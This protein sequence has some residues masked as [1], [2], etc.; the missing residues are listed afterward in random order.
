[1]YGAAVQIK[2]VEVAV[3]IRAVEHGP[4]VVTIVVVVQPKRFLQVAPLPLEPLLRVQLP[5]L[6]RELVLEPLRP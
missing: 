4:D 1:M 2:S 3:Q 6:L 5:E